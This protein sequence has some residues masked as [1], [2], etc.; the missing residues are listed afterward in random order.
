M[1]ATGR[2]RYCQEPDLLGTE[3]PF[4]QCGYLYATR[5]TPRFRTKPLRIPRTFIQ[6]PDMN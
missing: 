3:L 5:S 4:R 6:T 2:Q 1:Y